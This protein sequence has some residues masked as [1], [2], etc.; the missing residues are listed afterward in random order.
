LAK[1]DSIIHDQRNLD[2]LD[3]D[4]YKVLDH[5]NDNSRCSLSS[6][7]FRSSNFPPNPPENDIYDLH[8]SEDNK[9]QPSSS[10]QNSN[11]CSFC[12]KVFTRK[13]NLDRHL[14]N[15]CKGKTEKNSEKSTLEQLLIKMS[16]MEKELIELRNDKNNKINIKNNINT[17]SNNI[18]NNQYDI[19]I[20]A[21]GK[22]NLYD[23]IDDEA[24]KKYIAKGY[25]S[26]ISLIDYVHFNEDHPEL[27]NVYVSNQ[28]ANIAKVFN[29][30][31]WEDRP[32]EEV[33]DQLFDDKQCFLLDAYKE[34]KNTLAPS[35]QIKF[36]R[37]KNETDDEIIAG[38]KREIRLHLYNKRDIPMRTREAM[39]PGRC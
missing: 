28:R 21:F 8:S 39:K 20:M 1:N 27:Q 12:G 5:E 32:Q 9:N 16:L 24:A 35:A 2:P 26:V 23:R 22:E 34:V 33:V 10:A 7:K 4:K 18:N 3:D 15:R 14:A 30:T 25:Q 11:N 13:D 37:F 36:E 38:L 29:G 31:H 17:N 6:V 19:K